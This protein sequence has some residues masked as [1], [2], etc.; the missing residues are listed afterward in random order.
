MPH[1]KMSQ[2]LLIPRQHAA[3]VFIRLWQAA[4]RQ[5]HPWQNSS[6]SVSATVSS[7]GLRFSYGKEIVNSLASVLDKRFGLHFAMARN[8]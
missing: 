1:A 3:H 7:V 8:S 5:A 2:H 4:G 6:D